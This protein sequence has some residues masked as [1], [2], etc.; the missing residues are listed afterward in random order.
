MADNVIEMKGDD[1]MSI[2][3]GMQPAWLTMVYSSTTEH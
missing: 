2:H 3:N 1:A